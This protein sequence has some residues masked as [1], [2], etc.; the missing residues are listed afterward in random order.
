MKIWTGCVFLIFLVLLQTL[1]LLA[2][3]SGNRI[4]DGQDSRKNAFP[5]MVRIGLL[6]GSLLCGGTLLN[7]RV[8]LSAAHCTFY[9]Q[10]DTPIHPLMLVAYLGDHD[11]IRQEYGEQKIGVANYMNHPH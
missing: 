7:S 1:E 3:S 11:T 8:V 10:T 9:S 5:W 6:P 4:P 2:G